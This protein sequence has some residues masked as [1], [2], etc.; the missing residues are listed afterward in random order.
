MVKLHVTGQLL[1][2]GGFNA[3]EVCINLLHDV[4]D[5]LCMGA[6]AYPMHPQLAW[7]GLSS[8]GWQHYARHRPLALDIQ[9]PGM[10][11]VEASSRS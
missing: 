3:A 10:P 2:K 7:A 11:V 1:H 4:S 5:W 9:A 8:C 6:D